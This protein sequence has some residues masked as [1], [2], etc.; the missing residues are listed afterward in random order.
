[1]PFTKVDEKGRMILPNEIRRRMSI[2]TGDEFVI[3]EVGPDTILLRKVDVRAM[4]QDAIE[5]AKSVDLD[6]LQKDMG[7]EGDRVARKM[8]KVLD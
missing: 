2:S 8:Y 1:M 4:I 6:K 5:R 7:E 3:D